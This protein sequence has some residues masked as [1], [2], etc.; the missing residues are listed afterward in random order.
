MTGFLLI[1]ARNAFNEMNRTAMLWTIRREWPRGAKFIFNCYRHWSSLFIRNQ[2][3]SALCLHSKEGVTQG[4]PASMVAYGLGTLP[5]IRALKQ[6]QSSS[7]HI[8]YADD[9]SF[10]GKFQQIEHLYKELCRLGPSYGYYPE[11]NKCTLIVHD[12]AA[13]HAKQYFKNY[14]F[15][16]SHGKRFLGGYIGSSEEREKYITDKILGWETAISDISKVAHTFP[17]SA[18]TALSKSLQHEWSYLQ[19]VTPQVSDT[20]Q[21]LDQRLRNTFLPSLFGRQI[22]ATHGH[23]EALTTLPVTAGGLSI[24]NPSTE[25]KTNHA[26]SQLLSSHII[27][28]LRGSSPFKLATHMETRKSVQARLKEEKEKRNAIDFRVI[29]S[30]LSPTEQRLLER[31]K[32]SGHWLSVFP[33][34]TID[35]IVSAAEFRDG[36]HLR[37]GLPLLNLPK[38]CDGCLKPFSL[39]HALHCKVGGLVTQ[40]HD[41]VAHQL[42]DLCAQALKPS[43]VHAEPIIIHGRT[44]ETNNDNAQTASQSPQKFSDERG[45]LHIRGFWNKGTDTIVDVRVTNV[46]APTYLP[47]SV[48]TVLERQETEKKQK[49]VK[50]CLEQRKSFTPYVTSIDGVIGR[51]AN[52]FHKQLA[53]LLSHKWDKPYSVVR[54]FVNAKMSIACLRAAHHCIR[55]SRVPTTH[56]CRSLHGSDKQWEDGAGLDLFCT[57]TH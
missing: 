7:L 48:D 12:E 30:E 45:D 57:S 2:D 55:G 13:P 56:I 16:I 51:E 46:D 19:R 42:G 44:A 4:D 52:S 17:Q 5:L 6:A 28:S 18:Y 21:R 10:G 50:K 33:S 39:E 3:G 38:T 53:T 25:S 47:H 23:V 9:A 43:A 24:P 31:S 34:A 37:Y 27:T 35:T 11:E 14:G 26:N 36:L 49:Y 29:T 1:D 54:G 32:R 15:K 22:P 41:E 20:F 40:R 8:W